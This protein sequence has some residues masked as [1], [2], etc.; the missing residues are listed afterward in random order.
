MKECRVSIG[1]P[2]YNGERFLPEALDSLL[3]QTFTDFEVVISDNASTD[4]TQEICCT[5]VA[6]D[7]R[8]RYFRNE[9]NRGI[10][11]NHNNV[12]FHSR[13]EY[14]HWI[15]HDDVVAPQYLERCV[16]ILDK[17]PSI[18]LCYSR[19]K[20]ID[21]HGQFFEDKHHSM[22]TDSSQ[23]LIRFRDLV[24]IEHSSLAIFGV[25]RTE[26]LKKTI[27]HECHPSADR[28]LLA[29]LGLFG[30]FYQIPESLFFRRTHPG[31]STHSR[32]HVQALLFDPKRA[33]SI[34]LPRWEML[35]RYL[36]CIN[37]TPLS[38]YERLRCY[39]LV[40]K[41]IKLWWREMRDDALVAIKHVV[42]APSSTYYVIFTTFSRRSW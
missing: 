34:L 35:G 4:G 16:A 12:Y 5:Y 20:G 29:Q 26:V 9:E 39:I 6:R 25:M 7:S 2:V 33:G 17:D 27:L 24:C 15:G 28:V 41:A 11:W 32:R 37:K 31:Q 30:R 8:I 1:L 14:F 42:L 18:I 38:R 3:A 40:L 10:A 13:G 21:E 23:P 19:S 22:A 36:S